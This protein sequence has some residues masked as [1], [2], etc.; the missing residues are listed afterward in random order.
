MSE[1]LQNWLN[2]EVGLSTNVS[3]FEKDFASGYLFGEVLHKFRQQDGFDKFI[4]KNTYEA[5][6]SNFKRLEPTLKALGIKFNATQ[7]NAMMN[8]ERGSSLR[9]L[10]QLKMASERLFLSSDSPPVN[11]RAALPAGDGVTKT[12]RVPR[13][14]FDAH[15]QNFF[16]HRLR[17]TCLNV[18]QARMEKVGR[19]FE[20][21]MDKQE[22]LAFEMDELEQ[23][24]VAEQRD[25]HRF[26]L[27]ERLK[28][29]RA[30]KDD[31]TKR[32]AA[33][34]G[35]NMQVRMA[36]ESQDVHFQYRMHDKHQERVQATRTVAA[37][38]VFKGVSDFETGLCTLGITRT[39]KAAQLGGDNSDSDGGSDQSDN[40]ADRL[41]AQTTQAADA[42]ELVSVLQGRLPNKDVLEAEAG[43]FLRKIK[44]SK[45][46]GSI[47]RQE[48]ERRRRRVLVEQQREQDMLEESK[49]E[50]VLLEKISRESVEEAIISCRAWTTQKYEDVIVLNMQRHIQDC[51]ARR[52]H[53]LQEAIRRDHALREELIRE[54]RAIE[55]RERVR[56]RAL[57]RTRQAARRAKLAEECGGISELISSVAF[58]AAQQEQLTDQHEV[59]PTLWREWMA[60]FE[61]NVPVP[62]EALQPLQPAAYPLTALPSSVEPHSC[63][64]GLDALH[65]AAVRD[66][67]AGHGQWEVSGQA[68]EAL[69]PAMEVQR[70]LEEVK[71]CHFIDKLSAELDVVEGRPVNYRLGLLVGSLYDRTYAAALPP[72]PPAMPEVF[73]RLVLTGKPMAGKK[74]LALRL[75]DAYGLKVVDCDEVVRECFA[76]INRHDDITNPIDMLSFQPVS[77]EQYICR[78]EEE[79]NPYVRQLHAIGLEFKQR[80]DEGKAIT[81]DLYVLMLVTKIR[82]LFPDRLAQPQS[83]E[84]LELDDGTKTQGQMAFAARSEFAS[85]ESP[86]GWVMLGFPDDADRLQLLERFLSGWVTPQSA[87]VAEAAVLKAEAAL[88][89][90]RPAEEP[91][92]QD[93]VPGGYDLHFRLELPADE[94]VRRAC[95]RRLDPATGLKYHLEDFPPPSQHQVIYE[96]MVPV[97]TSS[98][99]MGTLSQ[100]THQFDVAQPEVDALLA[101]FGPFPDLPRLVCLDATK[102]VDS[103]YECLEEQV[104]MLLERKRA[105]RAQRQAEAEAA[106]L[107]AAEAQA[108]QEAA[109][110]AAAVAAAEAEAAR[111]AAVDAL[112]AA[113]AAAAAESAASKGKK[114]AAAVPAKAAETAAVIAESEEAPAEVKESPFEPVKPQELPKHLHRLEDQIFGLLMEEWRELQG[115]YVSSLQEFFKWHRS[116][117][118][119]IRSGLHGLKTRIL[120]GLQRQDNRQVLVDDFVKAFN[121]FSEEYPEMRKQITTK[122]ELHQRA[123]DLK[124]K[125]QQQIEQRR[126]DNESQLVFI[127]NSRWIDAQVEVLAAQAQYAVQ[128]EAKRYH[129]ACQLMSDFYYGAMNQPLPDAMPLPRHIDAIAPP[130][131]EEKEELDPKKKAPPPAKG[132]VAEEVKVEEVS[133]EELIAQRL[134]R[135]VKGQ[136]GAEGSWEFPFLEDLLVQAREVIWSL[137]D[138]TQAAAPEKGDAEAIDPKVKAKAKAKADPKDKKGKAVGEEVVAAP[139]VTPP[140]FI[141]LQQALLAERAAYVHRLGVIRDWA[142]RRL[143]S[144]SH[145]FAAT[146]SQLQSWVVMRRLKEMEATEGLVDIIKDHIESEQTIVEK[147]FLDGAQL[148]RRLNIHLKAPPAPPVRPPVEAVAPFRWSMDQLD[149]LLD[150]VSSACR[151]FGPS[152]LL[153]PVRNFTNLLRQITQTPNERDKF[154]IR[155]LVPEH[156][157]NASAL[158]LRKLVLMFEYPANS[159]LVDC[160]ELLVNIGLLHSPSGW[161][162]LEVLME[163]RHYLEKHLQQGTKW[164]DFCIN[165]Q[166]LCG[167]PLFK[168]EMAEASF[169]QRFRPMTAEKPASFNRPLAQLQW[170]GCVLNRFRAPAMQWQAWEIEAS[171]YDFQ[172]RRA[173]HAARTKELLDDIVASEAS[174]RVE[175]AMTSLLGPSDEQDRPQAFGSEWSETTKTR[176]THARPREPPEQWNLNSGD[177]ISVRQL[178]TYLCQGKTPEEGLQRALA[179]LGPSHSQGNPPLPAKVIHAVALQLGARPL[180]PAHLGDNRPVC[181]SLEQF[182]EALKLRTTDLVPQPDLA[183]PALRQRLLAID[184]MERRHTRAEVDKLFPKTIKPTSPLRKS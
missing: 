43:L 136:D 17:A 8:G 105:L 70:A 25:I 143:L 133:P 169:T 37:S 3:N 20:Q 181:L 150:S 47:A 41:L 179:V 159:G 86:G 180:S 132:K 52:K 11:S 117:Q 124:G 40:Q 120:D 14:K 101:H 161:P 121:S 66:Y 58:A 93:L 26:S 23:A 54:M 39:P 149:C 98:K 2:N 178:M 103:V 123:E 78:C 118:C 119:N 36:R 77:T 113:E 146:F 108:A 115:D 10:Y 31:W 16:E 50:E 165:S 172:V 88:I 45:R 174:P 67:I 29:N 28:Q 109:E 94:A 79:G 129:A 91:P 145:A 175:E 62:L 53:D 15:D 71:Q 13:E 21:E 19:K 130:V 18:K 164:P 12:I 152:K 107:A 1:L 142:M 128:L 83:V 73:V 144:L 126:E 131:K 42:R 110:A 112:A 68:V 125:L 104:A 167:A 49:L 90:P 141:D 122:Q 76:L 6:I 148:H 162:S 85:E 114:P 157:F 127:Q 35:Q 163:T 46:A 111:K 32:G 97:D 177:A 184:G 134:R 48:R 4:N 34:W 100:R 80:L 38:E 55:D 155:H 64:D 170:I 7:S 183:M 60:L 135:Y 106:L 30:A 65:R 160:A 140:L 59:D 51:N 89:A 138:Y 33:L 87:P 56:A 99:P 154:K 72:D 151:V 74:T 102:S 116:H 176:P 92:K 69:V 9:L 96:R 139:V 182:C 5:K 63:A 156:W 153:L 61:A 82:S 95:G 81:N 173:D 166:V 24:H 57:E 84:T 158:Q 137:K 147:L 75:A 168:D 27:R 22:I 171:W 44:E